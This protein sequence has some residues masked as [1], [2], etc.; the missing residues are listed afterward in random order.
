VGPGTR[1]N[2][3]SLNGSA[4]VS[5]EASAASSDL[6]GCEVIVTGLG[7]VLTGSTLGIGLGGAH[8]PVSIQ[9]Q[10]SL[11]STGT[12]IVGAGAELDVLDDGSFVTA[13]LLTLAAEP[14]GLGVMTV[15][16]GAEVAAA[17]VEVGSFGSGPSIRS[18]VIVHGSVMVTDQFQVFAQG[19]VSGSGHVIGD[20]SNAGLL[21][22]GTS[23]GRFSISG[24]FAQSSTGV[25][26][27]E[28]LGGNDGACGSVAV[29][30]A[31][32]LG[33]ML[34]IMTAPGLRP[35]PGSIFDIILASSVTGTFA[36]VVYPDLPG[37]VEL[38][39]QYHQG[40]VRV[41]A[42]ATADFDND[43]DVGNDTDIVAFFAC[44]GG[45]CCGEC[46]TQDFDG[47]GDSGTD[48]D[49]EAF[50]AALGGAAC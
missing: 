16:V 23:A 17:R 31:A 32:S 40:G 3:T 50:F 35:V 45:N 18:H 39:V 24:T 38:E 6:A 36:S 47:D 8:T 12:V 2:L 44:L 10:A 27:I 48:L 34:N 20:V 9:E 19:R 28:V 22:T 46:G 4:I 30:G 29:T 33:G 42:C 25:L 14:G 49:I 41:R 13:D 11:Q 15:G 26:S 7:S 37:G 21:S 43:G 1:V 5:G